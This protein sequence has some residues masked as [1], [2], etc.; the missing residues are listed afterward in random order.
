[1]VKKFSIKNCL[2]SFRYAFNGLKLF[3]NTQ[4]NA[5][6]HTIALVFALALGFYFQLSTSEWIVIAFAAGLVF[7]A[8]IINTSIEF[9]TDL[10]S[11]GSNSQAGKVKDLAAAAVLVASITA[12]LIGAIIFVPKIFC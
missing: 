4:R 1:M 6:I 11:P 7:T 8:E 5:W 2:N 3:F 10:V 12:L 9:L